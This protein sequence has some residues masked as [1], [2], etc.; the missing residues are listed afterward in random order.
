MTGKE[1]DVT[2]SI[3]MTENLQCQLLTG[4]SDFFTAMQADA[5]KAEKTEIL[6]EI[7]IV[8]YLLA[9]KMGISKDALD[10]KAVSRLKL[11][12][13]A[14]E[15]TQWRSALLELVQVLDRKK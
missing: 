2:K 6:A 12:L 1:L 8:L 13:L 4:V 7:E 3:K 11:G 10:Q 9:A 14:E 5:T 15:R